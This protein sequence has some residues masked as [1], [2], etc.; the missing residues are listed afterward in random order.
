MFVVYVCMYV[1]VCMCIYVVR[2]ASVTRYNK[3]QLC[4]LAARMETNIHK[5][6]SRGHVTEYR[7]EDG[8]MGWKHH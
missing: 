4:E 5:I 8:N 3:L 1:C 2:S 6:F 7:K